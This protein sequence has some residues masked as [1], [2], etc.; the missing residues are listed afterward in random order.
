MFGNLPT[1]RGYAW[2]NLAGEW[3]GL[4][5]CGWSGRL[6]SPIIFYKK[7]LAGLGLDYGGAF[8]FHFY[9]IWVIFI[10][11][12]MSLVGKKFSRINKTFVQVI[13]LIKIANF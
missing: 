8:F 9:Q 1:Q 2:P 12:N 4:A 6:H 7:L 3:P 10:I 5:P 13:Y 11:G